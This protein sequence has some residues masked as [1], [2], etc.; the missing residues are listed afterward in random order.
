VGS[1][2]E[3]DVRAPSVNDFSKIMLSFLVIETPG[4]QGAAEGHIFLLGQ[5]LTTIGIE[6]HIIDLRPASFE[7]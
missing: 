2:A 7:P 1:Q 6:F 4:Q 5:E 3:A